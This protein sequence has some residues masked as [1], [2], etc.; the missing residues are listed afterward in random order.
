MKF[1][2]LK[3]NYNLLQKKHSLPEFDEM[4]S[5]FEIG[6]IKKDSGV[7]LKDIRRIIVDKFAYYLKLIETMVNP[8]Q[9]PPMFMMLLKDITPE[10]KKIIDSVFSSFMEVELIS[11]KLDVVSNDNNEVE[12]ILKAFG[13]WNEKRSELLKILDVL[14]RNWK[15]AA[16]S[17]KSSRD[18]F[19]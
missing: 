17:K 13:V 12:F 9:A 7:L 6:K 2:E 5:A 1:I 14:E 16:N 8:S 10:D 11:Y 18:Y 4:N 3:N 19:N 15:N